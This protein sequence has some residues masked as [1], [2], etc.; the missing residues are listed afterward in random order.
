MGVTLAFKLTIT[1]KYNQEK[2]QNNSHIKESRQL[3]TKY[4]TTLLQEE[5][6]DAWNRQL[7]NIKNFNQIV[8]PEIKEKYHEHDTIKAIKKAAMAGQEGS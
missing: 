5:K 1:R 8:S 4:S 6:T 3:R 2:T 7:H